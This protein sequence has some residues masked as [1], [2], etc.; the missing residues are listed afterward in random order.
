[1]ERCCLRDSRRPCD[2]SC[3]RRV[4][5]GTER[6][7]A[8]GPHVASEAIRTLNAPQ[9]S[10]GCGNRSGDRRSRWRPPGRRRCVR[11]SPRAR[12][13][14]LV[15]GVGIP[16]SAQAMPRTSVRSVEST[17]CAP[18]AGTVTARL[19]C[20]HWTNGSWRLRKQRRM[21]VSSQAA[22]GTAGLRVG[23]ALAG[24]W[25]LRTV[26]TRSGDAQVLGL[27]HGHRLGVSATATSSSRAV[28]RFHDR[29]AGGGAPAQAGR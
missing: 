21:A 15:A 22:T 23:F 4:L 19:D 12:P 6:L 7:R 18:G 1:M 28:R 29:Y 17:W 9:A 20:Y 8:R 5:T 16:L 13:R 24:K 2:Y 25:K 14:R 3:L 26:V 11:P 10:D 27:A